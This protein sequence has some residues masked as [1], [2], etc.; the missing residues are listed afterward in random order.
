MKFIAAALIALASALGVAQAAQK[1]NAVSPA[2]EGGS[3]VQ[4]EYTLTDDAGTVLDSN[5]GREAL[6]YTQGRKQIIPGLENALTGMRA[7]QGKQVTVK[8]EDGYGPV[9]PKAQAEVAK[10]AIPPG[11]LKVGTGL[12][13]RG[14]SGE[15]R[16]VR[17]KEIKEKT[18]ILDLNHPLAG[19]T[20][21]FDVKVLRVDPPTR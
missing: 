9:D 2:I 11:A 13:A 7:G 6:T 5:K 15:G 1:E 4:L 21:H 14:P 19:K 16:P 17:V 18:V 8:P 20:L 10:D 12:M 3:K